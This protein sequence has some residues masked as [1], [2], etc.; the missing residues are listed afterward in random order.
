MTGVSGTEAVWFGS[1]KVSMTR[2]PFEQ[3]LVSAFGLVG[4]E[5]VVRV[6]DHHQL[7]PRYVRRDASAVLGRDQPV[8]LTM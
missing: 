4:E 7:G 2:E 5:Q 1:P 8:V 6:G 3:S